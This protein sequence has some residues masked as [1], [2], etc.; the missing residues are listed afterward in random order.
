M[1]EAAGQGRLAESIPA[2]RAR[3]SASTTTWTLRHPDSHDHGAVEKPSTTCTASSRAPACTSA[4][5]TS[6]VRSRH[7][8]RSTS[9]T[10]RW[11]GSSK[12]RGSCRCISCAIIR[13]AA[14]RLRSHVDEI[15]RRRAAAE[16]R[17]RRRGSSSPAGSIGSTELL[18]RA[19]ASGG[20]PNLSDT[21]G[22][23]WSSNGDFLT[24]AIH[25]LP[26]READS[27]ADDHVRDRSARSAST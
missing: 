27:R 7:A 17:S 14:G 5:A 25:P 3:R 1:H 19:Q 20:L 2:A 12:A 24:P 18:L 6:A 15:V 26:R 22:I 10:W 23:G 11:R 4:S 13:A 8:T 16:E 9:T 21:L